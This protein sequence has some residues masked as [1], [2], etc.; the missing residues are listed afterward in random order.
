MCPTHQTDSSCVLAVLS[1]LD[2]RLRTISLYG[3]EHPVH[4]QEMDRV[5]EGFAGL[6]GRMSGLPL[7]VTENGLQWEAD[8]V[9]PI[10][11]EKEGL[12]SAL[13]QAGVRFLAFTPGVEAEEIVTFLAAIH[14][15]SSFT[16]DDVDDLLTL[17]WTA[18]FQYIRHKAPEVAS[19]SSASAQEVPPAAHTTSPRVEDVRRRVEEDVRDI[20]PGGQAPG[21]VDLEKY[22][23]TLYFLDAS[24][25][26]Y[27]KAEI[28]SEYG[29]D[30]GRNVLSLLFD[31]FE[32]QTDAAVRSE[33][34]A[35]LTDM[36]P[37]LLISGDFRSVVYLISEARLVLRRAP[38]IRPDHQDQLSELTRALSAPGAVTQ[39]M[40]A[41][42]EARVEPSEEELQELLRE[43][44]PGALTTALKWLRRLSN[45]GV[46][47]LLNQ[48]IGL[49]VEACPDAIKAALG[50]RE[51][52]V[53]VEALRIVQ[54]RGLTGL[55]SQLAALAEHEDVRIRA[56]IVPALIRA[57]TESA[58]TSLVP[59]LRDSDTDIRIA[60]VKG[61]SARAHMG[62]LQ[63]V[64]KVIL[65]RDAEL[66]LTERKAFFE[67]YGSIAGEAAVSTLKALVLGG[68]FGKGRGDSDTRAC[69]TLAL[70]RVGTR[71]ARLIL[72]KAAKD[73]DVVVR[74]AAARALQP[75]RA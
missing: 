30:L 31:T 16:E 71:S 36:L 47:R 7:T 44:T 65:D 69:A 32:L 57:P 17:L 14:R 62:A 49:W 39:L 19:E 4:E 58:M 51:R 74:T 70:A 29:Q 10:D 6:W 37:Q 75:G 25:I 67:A 40:Q 18:D 8:D 72:Q 20:A 34:I 56:A 28:E 27:L 11:D 9:L 64:E 59:L 45:E 54:E 53:I 21:I 52:V 48:A 5:R 26:R 23:S 22:E 33:I 41:L 61:L 1:L 15:A 42:D 66:D 2:A 63:A 12:A 24:E 55:S 35:V 13:F 50:S 43:L 46:R 68:S 60:A 73:R 3:S 38:E